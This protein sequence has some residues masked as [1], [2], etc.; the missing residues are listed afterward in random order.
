LPQRRRRAPPAVLFGLEV[1][2]QSLPADVAGEAERLWAEHPREALG[3]LY[4]ALLSR[5]LHDFQLPLKG[6]HTEGEVLQLVLQLEQAELGRFA[7]ALTRHWQ[8]LAYGHRLPPESL[9]RGLCEGWRRLF[10]QV[11]QGA[12]A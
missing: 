8:N 7:Q 1:T 12:R 6:A 4:R 11:N 3:L 2:P 10:N 9:K 5:L